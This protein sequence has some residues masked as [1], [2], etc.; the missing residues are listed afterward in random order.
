MNYS[1]FIVFYTVLITAV[2][3]YGKTP[4]RSEFRQLQSIKH[5][6]NR[7]SLSKITY[8][9]PNYLPKTYLSKQG[10]FKIHYTTDG[11][12]AVSS[13]TSNPD[14]VPDWVY[15]TA[16]YA[17]S[18][19][20][21]LIDSLG[22]DAPPVDGID[23][24][25]YDIYIHNYGGAPYAN[26][27]PEQ[28]VAETDRPY[29]YI[30]YLVIDN[31]YVE[32]SYETNGYDALSVTVAHEYFHAIQMGY[33]FNTS[34]YLPGMTT[35]DAFFFEWSSVWFED[36]S[37]PEVNDYVAY[38]TEFSYYPDSEMWSRGYWYSHGIFM[39][40]ILENYSFEIL[41]DTW[42]KI[43]NGDRAFYALKETINE[44]TN[45]T[46]ARLYN[47]FSR[48]M[49]FTG[50]RYDS[51]YS[52]SKDAQYF[53]A[54]QINWGERY[55]YSQHLN[56]LKS[57]TPYTSLPLEISF[58]DAQYFG[59]LKNSHFSDN[60][61]GSYIYIDDKDY[62]TGTNNFADDFY[63]SK[64]SP[65]DTL[66][67]FI[68][69]SDER[70]NREFSIILDYVEPENILSINQLYPNPIDG[71]GILNLSISTRE[72]SEQ[73]SVVLYNLLGQ[74][75]YKK[76]IPVSQT[77]RYQIDLTKEIHSSLASGIYILEIK[78]DGKK[79]YRKFTVIK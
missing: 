44:Q 8:Q 57:L 16:I 3:S 69:N 13:E 28:E 12:N 47:D 25:E 74:K 30:S 51:R 66:L 18:A 20:S 36:Y 26:T 65:G 61:L 6:F 55:E 24:N 64:S 32:S 43:R 70:E 76:S 45:T 58:A 54:L 48:K 37:Y 34:D 35:G 22:F 62:K 52:V 75:I 10:N 77:K 29:D 17:E 78:D 31:D 21:T 41:L 40:Y 72:T 5:S 73:L 56:I 15:Y 42:E 67:V 50:V 79:Q 38:A 14:N 71:N 7:R 46:L 68:T 11:N 9:R 23:G 4:S 63:V 19:Y 49:Y 27:Y 60:F 1:K 39:K 53:P 33:S 2:F 59:F